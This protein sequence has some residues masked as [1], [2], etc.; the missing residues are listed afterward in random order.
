[1]SGGA[2]RPVVLITRP[3]PGASEL[4]AALAADG[5]APIVSPVLRAR[6]VAWDGGAGEAAALAFTSAAAARAAPGDPALRALPVWAVGEATAEAA[7]AAGFT[8]TRAGPSD[9]AALAREIAAALPTGAE[10]LHLR[11]RHG[12][13]GFAEALEAA[14]LR[15]R[16][17]VV[18]EMRA[19]EALDEAAERALAAGA[20]RAA[21]VYSPRS[22]RVLGRLA[23][24][25]G[26]SGVT[27]VAISEATAAPLRDAGF[28]R[29][30][31]AE[32]PTGAAMRA[33]VARLRGAVA[34]DAPAGGVLRGADLLPSDATGAHGTQDTE[35]SDKTDPEDEGRRGQ[36][37]EDRAV[38]A[39]DA[40]S[41]VPKE[42]GETDPALAAASGDEPS[43]TAPE[44]PP[45]AA[46]PA[47]AVQPDAVDPSHAPHAA[48]EVEGY[49]DELHEHEH[50]EARPSLAARTLQ[51]VVLLLIGAVAALWFGPRLAPSLPA[52]VAAWLAPAETVEAEDLEALRA[53]FEGELDARLAE[54]SEGVGSERSDTAEAAVE[55][56]TASLRERVDALAAQLGEAPP[57]ELDS[58]LGEVETTLSGVVAR[59]DSL[60][61]GLEEVDGE[62]EMPPEA[63]ERIAAFSASLEGV[64]AELESLSERV[65]A[66]AERIDEAEAD[67]EAGLN[68][69]I[70][71]AEAAEAA[72]TTEIAAAA[73]A[74]ESAERRAMLDVGF[75]AL[76]EA[77]ATGEPF[78]EALDAMAAEGEPPAA[79]SEAAAE[80]VPTRAALREDYTPAARAALEAATR[81]EAETDSVSQFM[82][83]MRAR[84]S[85]VPL[86]E[87]EGEGVDAMLGRAAARL[88][89][90]DVAAALEALE[91]MPEPA[92]AALADW[93]AEAEARVAAERAMADWRAELTGDG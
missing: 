88:S 54:L 80:G 84:L 64:Q 31:I 2:P 29:V 20:V 44:S 60:S 9:A 73:A 68:E 22:A 48:H 32:A 4:A 83:G 38:R 86:G 39:A 45:E 16:E 5:W 1:M 41:G 75:A 6:G 8:E 19:A 46:D 90:G 49:G 34:S 61:A 7:R 77:M 11:G 55:A 36:T 3:E 26:L 87:I 18:Y 24:P 37:G 72:A 14:G 66:L 40:S 67:Y 65:G 81:A 47:A 30:E 15:V 27:A 74:Q 89:E 85:G 76:T 70:E 51:G 13:A 78:L 28:G 21:P 62:S 35:M 71:A 58:R 50:E 91:D 53:E 12:T 42:A 82:A 52:P 92:R 17:G 69:A 57:G 25:F 33:A 56:A 43:G 79:L 63:M 10:V 93:R 59:L 23:A